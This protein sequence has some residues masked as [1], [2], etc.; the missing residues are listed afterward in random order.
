MRDGF[1]DTSLIH[2]LRLAKH[3]V[4]NHGHL[5]TTVWLVWFKEVVFHENVLRL[6]EAQRFKSLGHLGQ[7]CRAW[8][9]GIEETLEYPSP[10]E[11]DVADTN[12]SSQRLWVP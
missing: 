7:V 2:L 12:V 10:Y 6:V 8:R 4:G 1:I 9:G 3:L 5:G 11:A